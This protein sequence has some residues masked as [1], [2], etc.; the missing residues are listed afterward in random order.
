MACLS[1]ILT[2]KDDE[3]NLT[4]IFKCAC[5]AYMNHKFNNTWYFLDVINV[6]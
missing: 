6:E 5:F 3:D 1:I 2:W 4:Q